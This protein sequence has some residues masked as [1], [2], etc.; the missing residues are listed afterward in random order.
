MVNY[1]C[2]EKL[3]MSGD[4]KESDIVKSYLIKRCV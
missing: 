4:S 3:T 1:Q 2:F